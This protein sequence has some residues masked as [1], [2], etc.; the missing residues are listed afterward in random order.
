MKKITNKLR[1]E[2]EREINQRRKG[3]NGAGIRPIAEKGE[4]A[5]GFKD[6]SKLIRNN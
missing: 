1:K 6:A 2:K 4:K 5:L 3:T